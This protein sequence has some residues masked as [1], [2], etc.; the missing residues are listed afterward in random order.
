[1]NSIKN[2]FTNKKGI[3]LFVTRFSHQWT[4]DNFLYLYS[5]KIWPKE[6]R[7]KTRIKSRDF[8]SPKYRIDFSLELCPVQS[9]FM[10]DDEQEY[11]D[12]EFVG[13]YLWIES[14][15]KKMLKIHSRISIVDRKGRMFYGKG[16]FHS[17][18]FYF[19]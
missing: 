1:M 3:E 5:N 10:P 19:R 6:Q 14:L 7:A 12:D 17:S 18:E 13:V 2:Y 11:F 4:V 16:L 15:E 8:T 9:F